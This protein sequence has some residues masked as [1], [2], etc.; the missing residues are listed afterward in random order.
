MTGGG[1]TTLNPTTDTFNYNTT[2]TSTTYHN[3]ASAAAN[4]TNV[5]ATAFTSQPSTSYPPRPLSPES[6]TLSQPLISSTF[7]NASVPIF[8]PTSP[9]SYQNTVRFVA[10]SRPYIPSPPLSVDYIPEALHT[11]GP[12]GTSYDSSLFRVPTY[13]DELDPQLFG[14]TGMYH[15]G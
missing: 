10:E 12:G 3:A 5:S 14:Y 13:E 15:G 6:S 7:P 4:N 1:T 11:T 2:S 8:R 9:D